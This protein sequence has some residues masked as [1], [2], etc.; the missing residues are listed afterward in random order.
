MI[1]L[2]CFNMDKADHGCTLVLGPRASGKTSMIASIYRP[3]FVNGE[4]S[5]KDVEMCKKTGIYSKFIHSN[6]TTEMFD[7]W[8]DKVTDCRK[9][10]DETSNV[11]RIHLVL[12]RELLLHSK[13]LMKFV[14]DSRYFALHIICDILL[15][16]PDSYGVL[17]DA[18]KKKVDRLEQYA[19]YVVFSSRLH[20]F[21]IKQYVWPIPNLAIVLQIQDKMVHVDQ[22]TKIISWIPFP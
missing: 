6:M 4:L 2:P 16:T 5:P 18:F 13:N 20:P 10:R 14:K 3:I 9:Q 11:L 12:S 22:D 8:L 17:L 19:G 7:E 15:D 1:E 21:W